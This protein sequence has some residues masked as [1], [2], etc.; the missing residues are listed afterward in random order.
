MFSI[1]NKSITFGRWTFIS[2]EWL[3]SKQ[4]QTSDMRLQKVAVD[5]DLSIEV[6]CLS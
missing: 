1:L 2:N 3:N 4:I 5:H 6:R